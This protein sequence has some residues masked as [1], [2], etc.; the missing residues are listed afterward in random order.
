MNESP[1]P[2]RAW[3]ALRRCAARCGVAALSAAIALGAVAQTSTATRGGARTADYIVAVVNQELVTSVEVNQRL[4]RVR[5]NA[6]R[7][8]AQLPPLP[9]LRQQVLD[10]LIDE[11]VILS[12]A[13]D[14]GVRIEDAEL[15]RALAS[16]A[17]QNQVPP[18]QLR[19]RLEREG[20]D[21]N[22][23][24]ANIRDQMMVERVREREVPQRIRITDEEIDALIARERG[25]A[26]RTEFNVAQILV[27]VPENASPEAEAPARARAEAALARVRGGEDFATVAREVSEDS[28]RQRGGEIGMR[29]VDRLPDLFVAAVRPL[30]AGQ[31]APAVVRSG[32]GFHVLKLVDRRDPGGFTVTQTRA[33]HILLRP[34]AEG[35]PAAQRRL[36]EVRRQ[37]LAG[38]RRFEDVAREVSEDGSSAQGGDLGWAMP[39]S[40]VPEFEQAMN[41]LPIGGLS[42]P[43]LSRFGVHL[44]QV[45][46]RRNVELEPRQVRQ[47]AANVLREQKY[48]QAYIEWV[49]DLR[50]RA[51]IE[52]REGP[53]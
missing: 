26:A 15:E 32:A 22:R 1:N 53:Q 35:G 12:Y 37:I 45:M 16:V 14:S 11:R 33:R 27:P 41:A 42:E 43:V 25:A 50:S 4:A 7:A 46:E 47:Q 38:E 36:A 29:P 5:D 52:L 3:R 9:Q 44:I 40:F 2:T 31:V 28:N 34:T 48:E 6:Q 24:R 20:I 13:R 23:F 30:K 21:Y 49:R 18:A 39:G 17:A 19:Q 8:N 10:S 51:Y